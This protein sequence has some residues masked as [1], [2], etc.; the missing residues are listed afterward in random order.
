MPVLFLVLEYSGELD[1]N[2]HLP[3]WG[4]HPVVKSDTI[5]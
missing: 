1:N 5:I 2:V 3:N 4:L